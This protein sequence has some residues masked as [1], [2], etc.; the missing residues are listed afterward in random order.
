MG[1]GVK[2]GGYQLGMNR[3]SR[4]VELEPRFNPKNGKMEPVYLTESGNEYTSRALADLEQN[5]IDQSVQQQ[6]YPGYNDYNDKQ[7]VAAQAPATAVAAQLWKEAQNAYD[8]DSR[9]YD[10]MDSKNP[11]AANMGV[12]KAQNLEVSRLKHFDLQKMSDNAWARVGKQMT[13]SC[14]ARLRKMYP[15]A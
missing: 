5:E 15:N 13:T 11:W 9:R 1:L 14:Y 6:L 8:A 4:V 2:G 12:A 7:A 3:N 10:E